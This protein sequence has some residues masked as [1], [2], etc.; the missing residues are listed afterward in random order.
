MQFHQ[1]EH[2]LKSHLGI[3]RMSHWTDGRIEVHTCV[4]WFLQ[5]VNKHR[6]QLFENDLRAV[7]N[8]MQVSLVKN[9]EKAVLHP[10]GSCC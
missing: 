4:T 5:K 8:K 10:S 9:G 3:H 2:I 7:L 6:T 1:I